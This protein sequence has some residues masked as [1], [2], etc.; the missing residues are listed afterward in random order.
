MLVK[1]YAFLVSIFL[2]KWLLYRILGIISNI[3]ILAKIVLQSLLFIIIGHSSYEADLMMLEDEVTIDRGGII[4]S[5]TVENMVLKL[6]P[7]YYHKG[8]TTRSDSVLMPGGAMEPHSTLLEVSQVLKGETVP[9]GQ[10]WAGLPAEPISE[11]TL[12]HYPEC[13]I[14]V[15]DASKSNLGGKKAI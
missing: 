6:A 4:S 8:C 3:N 9:A 11:A 2:I 10:V 5:H 12:P 13:K 1:M 15:K 7:V 14:N